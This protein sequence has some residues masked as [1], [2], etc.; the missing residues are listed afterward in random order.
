M[1]D[2][3]REPYFADLFA[4]P[5]MAQNVMNSFQNFENFQARQ[6]QNEQLGLFN[7][8]RE[9][10][11]AMQAALADA[12]QNN[13]ENPTEA[14]KM[15][16]MASGDGRTLMQA[17]NQE[18][19]D[20]RLQLQ[21]DFRIL[22]ELKATGNTVQAEDFYRQRLEK[23][24]GPQ[25]PEFFKRPP[26]LQIDGF[27]RVYDAN[28]L[29]VGDVIPQKPDKD[30]APR[31]VNVW[32]DS[33]GNPVDVDTSNRAEVQQAL[34]QGF[35]PQKPLNPLDQIFMNQMLEN[36]K[37][38]AGKPGVKESNERLL[39]EGKTAPVPI[40]GKVF[41]LDEIKRLGGKIRQ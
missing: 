8:I 14:L 17:M 22:N 39:S 23:Q 13:P 21:N 5:Q 16:A 36:S 11:I 28:S 7:Q 24:F 34:S 10:E 31:P 15:A 18:R 33:Q 3:R 32:Y 35:T 26:K 20:S 9:Q 12:L 40:P 30:R 38:N 1:P 2:F 6:L 27:G 41:S 19:Q 25:P 4:P 29:Q 37:K